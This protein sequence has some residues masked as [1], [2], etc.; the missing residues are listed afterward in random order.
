MVARNE[1]AR[2]QI[3]DRRVKARGIAVIPQFASN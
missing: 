1:I 2:G 3:L